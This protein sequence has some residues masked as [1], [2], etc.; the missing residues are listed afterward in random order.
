MNA[1]ETKWTKEAQTQT[2]K[3]HQGKATKRRG[4]KLQGGC[5]WPAIVVQ[6]TARK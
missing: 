6:F 4:K 2:E 5:N 3:E 1:H